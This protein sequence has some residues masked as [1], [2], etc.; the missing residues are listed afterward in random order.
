MGQVALENFLPL[1]YIIQQCK[2]AQRL[3]IYVII[4]RTET[5]PQIEIADHQN[6]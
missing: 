1:K 6:H 2:Y 4:E 5:I 3:T